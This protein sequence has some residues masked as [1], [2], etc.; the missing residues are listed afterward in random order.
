[1]QSATTYLQQLGN[2]ILTFITG[3]K[4]YK[5]TYPLILIMYTYIQ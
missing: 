4:L 3:H 5:N 2:L 1:M